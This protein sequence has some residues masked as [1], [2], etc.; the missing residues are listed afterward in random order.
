MA[1]STE[2]ITWSAPSN[3]ALVKYWGKLEGQVPCNPSVSLTLEKSRTHT[4]FSWAPKK[5][6]G[7]G[8]ELEFS[9]HGKS[10][11]DFEAKI[12][13]FLEGQLSSRPYLA[14]WRL[15]MESR[16]TFPHSAGIASSA[17]SMA[18]LGLGLTSLDWA[19]QKRT[20]P[21]SP[22]EYAQFWSEASE[23]ARAASGSA[24]RSL[25][26]KAALWGRHP[27][28]EESSNLRAVP[29]SVHKDF[30]NLKDAILIIDAGEKGISSRAGHGL[31][32][33]HPYAQ[34]RFERAKKHTSICLSALAHGDWESLAK[35]TEAEALDLHAM[36]LTSD[37]WY[38]L[39]RPNTLAAISKLVAWR[40]TS[41]AQVCFT[42]D[43]GPNLHLIHTPGSHDALRDFIQN[44]LTP[45]LQEGKWI[46]DEMGEGPL[47]WDSHSSP[48]HGGH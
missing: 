25:F 6:P 4:T 37:P 2:S 17:S 41:K 23:L 44:E 5:D 46:D 15:V 27:E 29:I 31:M 45:L 32:N 30:Q 16:N 48:A 34:A 39:M 3:I 10:K 13:K 35:V 22:A 18:A 26:A 47:S 7:L 1:S 20:T 24:C 12:K 9:F 36:M 8:V 33:G 38:T 11:P 28:I 14:Q 42:L 43:A 40:E 21:Q 19:H